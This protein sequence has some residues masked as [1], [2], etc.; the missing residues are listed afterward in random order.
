MR[1]AM[2][3]M[4][5]SP[6]EQAGTGD[7]GGM[8]VYIRNT[9]EQLAKL[10]LIVDIFTRATRPL[11]GEGVE[12]GDG[13]RVIDCVAGSDEG[14]RKEYLPPQLAPFTGAVLALTR[15]SG[16]RHDHLLAYPW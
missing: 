8:N 7:A 2:I 15:D 11:E 14:L 3:S 10:G 1:V 13:V 16:L 4:H 12:L 9:A 5:T 6:L